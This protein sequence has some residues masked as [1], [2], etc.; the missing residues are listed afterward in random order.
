MAK[1]VLSE[2]IMDVEEVSLVL[3]VHRTQVYK[4]AKENRL[5]GAFRLGKR[6]LISRTVFD[7]WLRNP[8]SV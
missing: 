7:D 5:P 4:L 8:N 6:V 2:Q 1:S 3:G